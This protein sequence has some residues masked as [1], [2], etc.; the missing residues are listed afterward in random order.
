MCCKYIYIPVHVDI[1]VLA[2]VFVT[3]IASFKEA[4]IHRDGLVWLFHRRFDKNI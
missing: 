2:E 3:Q 1:F 4:E